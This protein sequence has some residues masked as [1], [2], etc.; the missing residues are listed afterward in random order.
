MAFD[1]R[2][3]LRP[4]TALAVAL[5][6]ALVLAGPAHA[7]FP[8]TNGLIA[9]ESEQSGPFEIWTVRSDGTEQRQL[10]T[11]RG[12]E[13]FGCVQPKFSPDG[14][15]IVYAYLTPTDSQIRVMNA[16]GSDS[17]TVFTTPPGDYAYEPTFSADGRQITFV[18]DDG[19]ANATDIWTMNDD[20]SGLTRLT[21]VEGT[22]RQPSWAPDG[23]AIA[24]TTGR[25]G[26]GEIYLMGPDGS[27][28]RRLTTDESADFRPSWSP[29]STRLLFASQRTTG[30]GFS[31]I[32]S[33]RADGAEQVELP[34]PGRINHYP[35]Y[36]PDGSQIV[37]M[38]TGTTGNEDIWIMNADG[39][40]PHQI[41]FNERSTDENPDWQPLPGPTPPVGLSPVLPGDGKGATSAHGSPL[42]H[43]SRLAWLGLGGALRVQLG[44][45]FERCTGE[46]ALR[47]RGHQVGR[48]E[49]DLAAGEVRGIDIPLAARSARVLR[50]QG[51]LRLRARFDGQT[52]KMVG[53]SSGRR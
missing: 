31:S 45:S 29:D 9:F 11:C 13:A 28:P 8:G 3:S 52:V 25:D 5:L 10:T 33:M 40:D 36:S 46:L 18:R 32:W 1:T 53:R 20:G 51:W 39:S 35:T 34:A 17:H 23:S 15:R 27:D 16:D 4:L 7:T 50:R 26:N 44:C 38:S 48:A 21:E 12:V 2:A 37:Y 24:F 47:W 22:D 49:Y 6:A 14:K 42:L 43:L 41:T 30:A 19:S